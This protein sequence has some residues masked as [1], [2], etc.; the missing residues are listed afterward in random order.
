MSGRWYSS[1]A[2]KDSSYGSVICWT[3]DG[4]EIE[5]GGSVRPTKTDGNYT[6]FPERLLPYARICIAYSLAWDLAAF[7]FMGSL[8]WVVVKRKITLQVGK[9]ARWLIQCRR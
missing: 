3:Q 4:A 5:G 2:A 9:S 7:A 6:S 8:L 1:M